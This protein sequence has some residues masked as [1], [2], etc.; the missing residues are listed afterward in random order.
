MN[1]KLIGLYQ[2]MHQQGGHF[3]GR[4]LLPFAHDIKILMIK[5]RA[6]SLLDYGCGEGLQYDYYEVQKWWGVMPKLYDP[7]IRR[8]DSRPNGHFDGVICTDVMEHVPEDELDGVMAD[9]F[10][11]AQKFIFVSICCRP[12]KRKLPDGQN[13]HVT[14][15]PEDWWKERFER[16]AK[17]YQATTPGVIVTLRFSP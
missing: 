2:A 12:A 11:Y 15:K 4:S 5:T 17:K 14:I 3:P 16:F 10:K 8:F 13:C 6:K 1:G 9:L 7:A